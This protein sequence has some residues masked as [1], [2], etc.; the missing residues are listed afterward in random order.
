MGRCLSTHPHHRVGQGLYA[1]SLMHRE[2]SNGPQKRDPQLRGLLTGSDALLRP[3]SQPTPGQILRSTGPVGSATP[4][5]F[6]PSPIPLSSDPSLILQASDSEGLS[7]HQVQPLHFREEGLLAAQATGGPCP[8]RSR[9]GME[10]RPWEWGPHVFSPSRQIPLQ[11]AQRSASAQQVVSVHPVQVPGSAQGPGADAVTREHSLPPEGAREPPAGERHH[12]QTLER[13]YKEHS[14]TRSMYFPSLR[15]V[16][17]PMV[18]R[19]LKSVLWLPGW[20]SS[21]D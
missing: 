17:R 4:L 1:V 18:C 16:V 11:I 15:P 5:P 19:A 14:L 10:R 7:D 6:S 9:A 20:C 3:T 21:V 2:G 13:L 12:H 8:L